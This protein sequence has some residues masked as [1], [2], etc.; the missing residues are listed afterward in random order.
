MLW[1]AICTANAAAPTTASTMPATHTALGGGAIAAPGSPVAACAA[2]FDRS[3]SM[4]PSF[5]L[6]VWKRRPGFLPITRY[7]Y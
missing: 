4:N 2:D 7:A 6:V 1:F 5:F 3:L